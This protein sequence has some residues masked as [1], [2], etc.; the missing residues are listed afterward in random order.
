MFNVVELLVITQQAC[1]E[2]VTSPSHS[3]QLCTRTART[4]VLVRPLLPVHLVSLTSTNLS[5]LLFTR[6]AAVGT[7]HFAHV[8]LGDSIRGEEYACIASNGIL[9]SLATGDKQQ[10]KPQVA[11]GESASC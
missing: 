3:S 2:E 1:E 10:I 8:E 11:A 4:Y 6:G 7:L 9:G 5:R